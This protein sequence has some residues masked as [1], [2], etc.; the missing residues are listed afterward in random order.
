MHCTKA[1]AIVLGGGG[2]GGGVAQ[3]VKAFGNT[4]LVGCTGFHDEAVPVDYRM[5][6][7]WKKDEKMRLGER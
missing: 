2:Y 6:Y 3:S 4:G 1:N 5:V 7:L